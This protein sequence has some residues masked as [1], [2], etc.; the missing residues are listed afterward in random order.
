MSHLLPQLTKQLKTAG[1][2]STKTRAAV[3]KEL[4]NHESLTMQ[5][6]A[7][8]LQDKV[9]RASVYRTIDLF[10]KLGIVQR[11]QIGWKYRLEL[12]DAF[13]PHH[14]H[15]HCTQCNKVMSLSENAQLEAAIE[16][17]ADQSGFKLQT[18][19]LELAG[20]CAKCQKK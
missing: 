12:S 13:N 17:I 19:Q 8:A 5:D 6:L 20:V 15:I 9:D 3:F 1:Y 10:E 11:V 4:S 7:Y 18:H 2:S 14:H 16:R